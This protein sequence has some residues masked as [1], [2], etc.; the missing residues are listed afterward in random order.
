MFPDGFHPIHYRSLPDGVTHIRKSFSRTKAGVRYYIS[1]FGMSTYF[2]ADAPS[3]LVTGGVGRER[4]PE[5]S[6]T[7]PYDPFMIDVYAIGMVLK[8]KL[9]DVRASPYVCSPRLKTEIDLCSAT[10]TQDFS[11]LS[12]IT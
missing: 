8:R 9:L 11:R 6:W 7:V 12:F 10:R 2:P 3:R 1:D 4:A 5:L